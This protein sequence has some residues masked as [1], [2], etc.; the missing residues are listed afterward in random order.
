MTDPTQPKHKVDPSE[1]PTKQSTPRPAAEVDE[2][3]QDEAAQDDSSDA[4]E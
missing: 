2:A 1:D 4:S 3:A